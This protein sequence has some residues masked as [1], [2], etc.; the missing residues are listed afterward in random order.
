MWVY[1]WFPAWGRSG[2]GLYDRLVEGESYY[3]HAPL[4]PIFSLGMGYL[5]VRYAK[6]SIR[7]RPILGGL[8]L[9]VSLLVQLAACFVGVQFVQG[10]AFIGVV[11][12]LVLLLWG[13][14]ALRRLWFPIAMLLFMMPL[15]PMAIAQL[16]FRLKMVAADWGVAIASAAG[17]PVERLGAKLLIGAHKEMVVG[18]VCSGLRTLI[19]LLG[20]G[21]VYVYIC[22]LRGWWRAGLFAATLPV[23]I[24][25]NCIRITSLIVVAYLWDVKTATGVFHDI[26]GFLVFV[27]AFLLM[28]GMEHVILWARAAVGRPAKIV[29]ILDGMQRNDDR[30]QLRRLAQ[31]AAGWPGI[32]AIIILALSSAGVYRISGGATQTTSTSVIREGIPSTLLAGSHEYSSQDTEL[33]ETTLTILQTSDYVMRRYEA[34]GSEPVDLCITYSQGNRRGSHP[35]DVCLEGGGASII[36]RADVVLPKS[37][38]QEALP[39]RELI[40]QKGGESEYYLYIYLYSCRC[41]ASYTSNWYWQQVAIMGGM[42]LGDKA[43][44]ALIR[45][46]IPIVDN[47]LP[48]SRQQSSEFMRTIIPH[49]TAAVRKAQQ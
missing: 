14:N 41:E 28:F 1:H 46:S 43:S 40:L 19:S 8:V 26:S 23:A 24:V 34:Q 6:I 37:E 2:L 15:P 11:V 7:P 45:I 31:T 39:C 5:L 16:N 32:V 27:S 47:D 33:D 13:A 4:V 9:A 29:E 48:A 25:S 17:M 44:G 12:G 49:V 22:K 10:F 30:G 36:S 3:T 20:F 21:A 42:L 35:P 38:D 18:N